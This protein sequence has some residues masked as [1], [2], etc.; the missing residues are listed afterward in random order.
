MLSIAWNT[1]LSFYRNN[2]V[3]LIL[4]ASIVFLLVSLF[5]GQLALSE[6]EKIVSDFALFI[7]E[8][9]ALILTLFFGSTLLFFEKKQKTLQLILLKKN[10]VEFFIFGKFLW[11][12]F[13]IF[14]VAYLFLSWYANLFVGEM[15]VWSLLSIGLVYFKMLVV[16]A[17]VMFF[18]SFVS[19]ILS[20]ISALVIYTVS[21]LIWFLKF[22]MTE[23][24]A[25]FGVLQKWIVEILYYLLPNFEQLSVKEYLFTSLSSFISVWSVFVLIWVHLFYILLLLF[26]TIKIYYISSHDCSR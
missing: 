6:Q 18:S 4:L 20:L 13:F 3:R 21:H 25:N 22:S 7:I 17:F 9:F 11:F 8:F 10:R 1:F 14:L 16:L 24:S 23:P 2:V 12:A 15:W 5:L 19:P 26:F